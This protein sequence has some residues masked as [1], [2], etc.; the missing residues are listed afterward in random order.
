[1]Q[2]RTSLSNLLVRSLVFIL[3]VSGVIVTTVRL[4]NL[5]K[6]F[7][8]ST[9]SVKTATH[10]AGQWHDTL[11]KLG[12]EPFHDEFHPDALPFSRP[13][14]NLRF[15]LRKRKRAFKIPS[16]SGLYFTNDLAHQPLTL[17]QQRRMLEKELL[18]FKRIHNDHKK[19][20]AAKERMQR[21]QPH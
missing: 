5:V 2:T 9:A 13:E 18:A 14:A 1:M 3:L 16:K 4:S 7:V 10:V 20:E 17:V 6:I 19:A 12:I 15:D 8:S 11:I 21:K